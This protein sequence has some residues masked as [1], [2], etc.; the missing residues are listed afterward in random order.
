MQ[1]ENSYVTSKRRTEW[2]EHQEKLKHALQND[3]DSTEFEHLAAALL[4]RLLGVPI[5][6]ASSGFQHGADAG[7]AGRQERRF[8]LECK[9][10]RDTSRLNER[11]LL[12]EIDQAIARDEELEAWFLIVTRAVPEQI[13]KSLIQNGERNGVPIVI[14]DWGQDHPV[15]P[16]AALCAF[17]P[18]LVDEFVSSSA[19]DDAR[20]LQAVSGNAIEGLRRDLQSW[21]LGFDS[22]RARSLKTLNR[23]WNS[24]RAS[25]AALGQNAAG[26]AQQ[27]KVKRSAVHEAL[28]AWWQGP[29]EHDAPAAVVGLD[30]VGKTWATL[31]WLVDSQTISQ[32]Y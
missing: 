17:A 19:S 14:I 20:A 27:K 2:R 28:T 25:T 15:A 29:A 31:E 13:Q 26:G 12:G 18:D 7:P 1:S 30:G 23:I 6:V 22:L 16:L 8:R 21:C 5:A 11:E 3:I 10:Y 9:R 4:S 32:L 24:P